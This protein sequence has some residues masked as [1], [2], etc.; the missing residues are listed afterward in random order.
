MEEKILEQI[1]LSKNETKVY[2]A[3]LALD[4]SSA[5]PI[6]RKSGI[7]N[8]KIYP[9]LEK[10]IRRGLVS[11]VIKN[12]VKHFQLSN[13][14]SLLEL[15]KEKEKQLVEQEQKVET[16]V[17]QIE[18]KRDLSKEKQ[19]A[20]VFEGIEGLRSAFNE[21]LSSLD[22][23]EE[24]LVFTL[25]EELADEGL[26]RFFLDYHKKRIE[27]GIKVR[28]I[29]NEKIKE[30]FIKFHSYKNMKV[31][32]T[33]STLPAGT[34]IYKNKVMTVVWGENPTAFVISSEV[35]AERYHSFFEEIWDK[36]K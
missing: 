12:N 30:I 13:P 34:F 5:T 21:I 25:G 1:G 23:N 22:K 19:E 35:N 32:F 8:S 16:L 18:E 14:Q 29:C 15:L 31:K 4:Q 7:P 3:L 20:S 36:T 17:E 26:K 11:F 6:V 28:L 2:F 27:K 9:T 33:K 10:L 24:Y